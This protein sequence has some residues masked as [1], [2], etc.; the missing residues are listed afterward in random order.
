MHHDFDDCCTGKVKCKKP[1]RPR[2]IK[3]EC[4]FVEKV[5]DSRI[6]KTQEVVDCCPCPIE[7]DREICEI[8]EDTVEVTCRVIKFDPKIEMLKING[9]MVDTCDHENIVKGPGGM[10]QINLRGLDIDFKD[11]I[12][13]GKGVKVSVRQKISVDCKVKVTVTGEG[14][15][16]DEHGCPVK[17]AF[18]GCDII[19]C[20]FEN[21]R[22]RFN[23]M[24]IPNNNAVFP[25]LIG[26]ACAANCIFDLDF[27]E[28]LEDCDCGS[29]KI[30]LFGELIFCIKCEKKIKFP[31]E[32]CVLSTGFC[33]EPEVDFTRCAQD[34]FPDLFPVSYPEDG[35]PHIFAEEE[36]VEIIE[37]PY[38]ES[39]EEDDIYEELIDMD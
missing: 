24:C 32:L 6:F 38:E 3:T 1:I 2:D 36:V 33:R 20:C 13:K 10:E 7:I 22:V 16:Y 39:F 21:I 9:Q 37:E 26:D 28:L 34:D 12:E 17:V 23:D 25:V 27:A 11:C 30:K 31:V 8:I 35:H 15:K 29:D 14:I 18:T 5:F 4:I 19:E